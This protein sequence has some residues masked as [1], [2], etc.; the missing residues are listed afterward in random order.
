MTAPAI[1]LEDA[2]RYVSEIADKCTR[3]GSN[4]VLIERHVNEMLS[5]TLAYHKISQMD[6][7]FPAGTAVA[8][9]DADPEARN[10]FEWA[11]D[12]NSPNSVSFKVFATV[13]EAES[14]LL[15]RGDGNNSNGH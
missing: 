15:N 10:R 11:I 5:R 7:T 6:Q 1:T 12:R 8:I 3:L 9:V 14:W 4:G 13:P 2:D